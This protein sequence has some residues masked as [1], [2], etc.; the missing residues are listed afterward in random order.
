[1]MMTPHGAAAAPRPR[2]ILIVED[3]ALLRMDLA[4]EFAEAGFSVLEAGTADEALML[5]E[6]GAPVDLVLSD[7]QMPGAIDG[8]GLY[9]T[10]VQRFPWIVVV[11][12]SA[13]ASCA[14]RENLP[15]IPKPYAPRA[16][17]RRVEQEIRKRRAAGQHLPDQGASARAM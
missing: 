6:S 7:I 13:H 10:L 9:R 3:E 11:L 2:T 12:T 8:L 1:M 14:V 5:V 17:L 15:F 16:A 4:D